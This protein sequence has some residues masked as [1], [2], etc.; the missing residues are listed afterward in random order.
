MTPNIPKLPIRSPIQVDQLFSSSFFFMFE[1][2][3]PTHQGPSLLS[4]HQ[5]S[6]IILSQILHQIQKLLLWGYRKAFVIG[7]GIPRLS[8]PFSISFGRDLE[9]Q[10]FFLRLV[11][12]SL[13]RFG[14]SSPDFLNSSI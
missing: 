3:A 11:D 6:Q 13:P 2:Q 12:I 10:I 9:M 7:H 4:Q 1:N 14:I 8:K 5:P